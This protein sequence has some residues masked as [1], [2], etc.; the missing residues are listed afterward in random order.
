MH[1]PYDP[2]EPYAQRFRTRPVE[3]E[4]ATQGRCGRDFDRM[5]LS[6]AQGRFISDRYDAGIR[7]AD[8]LLQAFLTRLESSGTL[9]DTLIVVLSD[10]GEQFLEHGHVG[11][12]D[13]QY[14]EVLRIPWVMAGPGL[15]PRVVGEPVGLADVMP[16][17]LDLLGLPAP[18]SAGASLAPVLR[19]S[20]AEQRV[21][22]L[23]S[24]SDWRVRLRSAVVGD[25]HLIANPAATEIFDWRADPLE[26]RNILGE[27]PQRDARLQRELAGHLAESSREESTSAG[28]V[29][30]D[31]AER[32]RLHA[33]GYVD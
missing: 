13:T 22:P 1:C 8:D 2:P 10:H 25:Y 17:L 24:E 27:D 33:L 3:D 11:H 5:A 7:Y 30:L 31:E 9:G 29:E 28:K 6:R 12:H 16:T 4:V 20:A 15:E 19:R 14:M 18:P 23:F 32:R 26:Q 21:R